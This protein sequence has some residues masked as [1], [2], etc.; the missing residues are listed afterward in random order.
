MNNVVCLAILS[1]CLLCSCLGAR[2]VSSADVSPFA[3]YVEG[4]NFEG[5]VFSETYNPF[6][7][8]Y[9]INQEFR[10]YKEGVSRRFTPTVTQIE[11]AERILQ[12][13]LRHYSRRKNLRGLGPVIHTRLPKYHRQYLGYTSAQNEDIVFINAGRDQYT[14]LDRLQ[15]LHPR[16]TTWKYDYQIV[17]DGGSYYWRVEVNLTTGKLSGFGV[18]GVAFSHRTTHDRRRTSAAPN[19]KYFMPLPV[20]SISRS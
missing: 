6:T 4:S 2:I 20:A 11:L 9:N 17:M 13:E 7:G 16:N 10:Q 14:L 19:T 12:K 3:T 1:L 5:V 15:N 18:N 8:N